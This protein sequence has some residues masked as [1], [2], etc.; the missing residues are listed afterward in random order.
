MLIS[1]IWIS[2][3]QSNDAL[4]VCKNASIVSENWVAIATPKL[5][6]GVTVKIHY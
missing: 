2:V 3:P 1:F 4:F 6:L 5:N